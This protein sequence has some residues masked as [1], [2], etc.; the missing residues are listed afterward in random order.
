[1][2][3]SNSFHIKVTPKNGESF[4]VD[5]FL[6]DEKKP[7]HAPIVI[8]GRSYQVKGREDYVSLFQERF[9]VISE[10]EFKSIKELEVAL[11][12]PASITKIAQTTTRVFHQNEGPKIVDRLHKSNGSK[13]EIMKIYAEIPPALKSDLAFLMD[14]ALNLAHAGSVIKANLFF[15]MVLVPGEQMDNC[16][17]AMGKAMLETGKRTGSLDALNCSY[18]YLSGIKFNSRSPPDDLQVLIDDNKACLKKLEQEG[19]PTVREMAKEINDCIEIQEIL[20][21]IPVRNAEELAELRQT[22]PEVRRAFEL[23]DSIQSRV[24]TEQNPPGKIVPITV[25]GETI[26]MHVNITGTKKPGEPFVIMEAGL[27]VI[28]EDWQL[29]QRGMP[30]NIQVMS[31]D[32]AGAGWSG[33]SR[34]EPTVE[35]A[36]ANLEE[37]LK[38]LNIE[39][40]YIFVGHSYGGFLG[41][42]FALRHPDQTAGLV[43]VDSAIEETLPL[44]DAGV[45]RNAFDYAPAAAQNSFFRQDRGHFFDETSG[46]LVHR[47]T[48]RT[49]HLRTYEKEGDQFIRTASLLTEALEKARSE[50]PNEPPIKC[51]MKVITAV[52]DNMEDREIEDPELRERRGRFMEGQ[53]R[54]AD[55]SV[56]GTQVMSENSDHFVMYHDPMIVIDQVKDFFK[57]R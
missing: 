8:Q 1:M 35:N 4:E 47:V 5:L 48:S 51:P 52:K 28:S 22:N 57:K 55:R 31:Y 38:T 17:L 42:L 56:A 13:Q 15:S 10:Q 24:D 12:L 11:E 18:N 50:H 53:R 9:A 32:R 2:D 20:T 6:S 46:R 25:K 29:V 7:S 43:M 19:N 39:P 30:S 44:S 21:P 49:A 33:P 23:A 16:F 14:I 36:L 40:P 34:E 41:Q 54:L 45:N 26:P 27:G 37:L 3:S